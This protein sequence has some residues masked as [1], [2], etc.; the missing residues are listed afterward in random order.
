MTTGNWIGQNCDAA[1]ILYNLLL[2]FHT[3]NSLT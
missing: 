2:V 3:A 1:C